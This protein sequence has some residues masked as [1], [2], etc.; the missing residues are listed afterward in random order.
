MHAEILRQNAF[1]DIEFN[2]EKSINCQAYSAALF[3]SLYKN[4]LLKQ[5]LSDKNVFLDI[6]KETYKFRDQQLEDNFNIFL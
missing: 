6:L 1:S 3:V 5:A 4:D 2:A